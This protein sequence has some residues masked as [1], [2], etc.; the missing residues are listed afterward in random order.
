MLYRIFAL[1]LVS[2]AAYGQDGAAIYKERC[3]ACHDTGMNRA[4][5]PATLKQLSPEAV[6]SALL[7]GKMVMMGTGLSSA[8]VREVSTFVTG[9]QFGGEGAP[10][11]VACVN[12]APALTKPLAGPHW[13]GW[14][15]DPE[16]HRFQPAAMAKLTAAE[17]PRLKLKWA[18]GFAGVTR[19]GSQPTVVGGRL[20]IGSMGRHVYSLDAA[21][22]CIYWD[23]EADFG[24]RSAITVG[25]VG[26]SWAA[27]F[28]DQG[29]SAYAVDANTGKQLWK[30]RVDDFPGATVTGAPKLYEG[31]LY[32]P[33]SSVEEVIGASP[34]YECCK[35][36]GSVTALDAA[37]GKQIWKA[38]TIPDPPRPVRKNAAGV[39]LWGPSGVGI[40]SSPTIDVKKRALYI[41]TGDSYSEPAARTSDAF[42]AYDLE[43][44]KLL[45]SRQFT[46]GDAFNVACGGP[47]PV[48]CPQPAGPDHDFGSSPILVTLA[49]GKRALVAG[50]KSGMVH[51][52]DPDQQGEVLWQTRV[53]EGGML[54]GVQWGS[55]VDDRNIYVA[56]SDLKTT[57]VTKAG[58]N[59]QPS[60]MGGLVD[61]DPK[62]GGGL[63][64]L[65]LSDGK[66]VWA[67]PHPGCS[68]PACSPAQSAAVTMIPGVIFSGGVDGHLR[69]YAARDGKIVWDVDTARDYE[70]VN[71]IKGAG[72][73]VDGPGPVI[74]NGLL[75]VNSGYA[76]LGGM[77]GNVLL[78]FSVDGK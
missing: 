52:V 78:A 27:Y 4:P 7:T 65:R 76:L 15:A 71:G 63:F 74:V 62:A 26:E 70:T 73:S 48:N 54:G 37:T 19:A 23:F 64:A 72:G 14:S 42:I 46:S 28:G 43:T 32:V 2:L 36:R 50:Q 68:K 41:A 75:Y 1:A 30:T 61:I 44:G 33:V 8:Q 12:A 39:Q 38:Y 67:T 34:N 35:F 13:N 57:F 25:P 18:F 16:N 77:P 9:K 17:T 56:L 11:T 21:S 24:V 22:G 47:A 29:G 55:A 58:P 69:A 31:R 45:W 5:S 3:A 51:A 59:T 10:K 49:N 53:G 6:R 40:W 20:F 66:R 60:L